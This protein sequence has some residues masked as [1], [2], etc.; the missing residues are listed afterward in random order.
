MMAEERLLIHLKI[1]VEFLAH[2]ALHLARKEG[3]FRR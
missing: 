2:K 3:P 1:N